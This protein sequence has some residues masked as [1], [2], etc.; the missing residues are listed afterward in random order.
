MKYDT[1]QKAILETEGDILANTG[2]QV[3]K[4]TIFSHKIGK[5]MMEHKGARI[6]VV[7]LTEDQ[8]QLI[9]IMVLDYL[10]KNCKKDIQTGKNKP[11]KSRVYLK[12]G[13]NVISRPVGNTGDAVRGFTGDVLYIDEASGMPEL[14]WKASMP[15][16]MTTGGQIWMSSTPRGK[17]IGNTN[18]K[19][20]FYKCWE[21]LENRWKIFNITAERVIAEREINE[22][23]TQEKRDKA[24]KFLENQKALLSNIEYRQEYL[25]EFLDEMR[26]WFPDELIRSC[27]TKKRPETINKE[28]KYFIGV[29]VARQGEDESSFEVIEYDDDK[30]TQVENQITTKTLLSQ[31][32]EHIVGLHELY[33][34]QKIFIDDEGIGVGVLDYLITDDRTKDVS[35]GLRNSKQIIDQ[36]GK[37]VKLQKT[38]LYTNLKMLMET[39]KVKLLDDD[40]IFQSLKSVQFAY[41]DDS[42]GTR[43]LK[44]FG[45]YTHI[46][47]GL[48]R[49][50]WCVKYKHL[51]LRVYSI[52]I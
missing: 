28:K 1:W 16:L 37:E 10:E 13:S 29:D 52:K 21:N 50:C 49:A 26:Q 3:G 12:N 24:L 45:N 9:I 2:R 25:G 14:M 35:I 20:F 42:A 7:S 44:I 51:N 40:K 32:K 47:E 43:H 11:T 30:I 8:A 36:D 31:T 18:E 39:G 27:M 34:F 4:T 15:T 38:L 23:W 46:A 17:Y 33:T 22:D 19:N 48:V 6:I 5:Y 41:S